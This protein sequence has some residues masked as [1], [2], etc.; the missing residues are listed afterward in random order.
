MSGWVAG[1]TI[2]GAVGGA[3][4][5]SDSSRSAANKQADAANASTDAQE[6][7]Y[8]Q[9]REDNAPALQARNTALQRLQALLGTNS[10]PSGADV[11]NEAGYQFGLG[12]GQQALQ[13]QATARGM[14]N[15]GQ[16]LTAAAR[17]G[18]D[19]AT[20]KYNDAFNRLQSSR[21]QSWNEGAS[22]AGLGQTGASQVAASGQN[23]ANVA[24]SNAL[25]VG[26]TQA[27]ATI[28]QGNTWAN[29]GNQLAGWYANSQKTGSGS[30]GA[31]SSTGS[32]DYIQEYM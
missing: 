1:T 10:T 7:M 18:N 5:A 13:R 26:N 21:Q 14:S 2:V 23:A 15:S 6:R 32:Y 22:L 11:Q 8:Q 16:A 20:T 31:G 19:Y 24:S 9:T 3:L 12:Q 17:Y 4:I 29:A 28:A 30:S 27:A 25:A